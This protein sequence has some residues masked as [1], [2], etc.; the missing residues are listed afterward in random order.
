MA[1]KRMKR[2]TR[3]AAPKSAP[4]KAFRVADILVTIAIAFTLINAV[5]ILFYADRAVEAAANL[6]L[7]TTTMN[8][9]YL[10]VS[11]LFLALI[12]Y[13]TNRI[14]R[15]SM[16]RHT[17]WGLLLVG[18]LLGVTGRIESAV[19]IVIAALIYIL[20]SMK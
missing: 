10:G 9:Q 20:K 17:M 4:K 18:I 2:T 3:R 19:L 8:W 1:K 6:G 12:A 14:T 13:I 15:T 11:W 7:Q 16:Y 5:L